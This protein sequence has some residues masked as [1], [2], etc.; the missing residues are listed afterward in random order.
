MNLM[1][2]RIHFDLWIC[3][4]TQVKRSDFKFIRFLAI[5]YDFFC[6]SCVVDE[7]F[8]KNERLK[9]TRTADAVYF[10]LELFK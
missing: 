9:K 7:E 5:L 6:L 1:N 2:I 3:C 4:I 10:R 8:A